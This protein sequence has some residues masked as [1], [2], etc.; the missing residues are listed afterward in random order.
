MNSS[1]NTLNTSPN[2]MGRLVKMI[3]LG[4]SKNILKKNEPSQ[5]L[6]PC[7][8]RNTKQYHKNNQH[9]EYTHLIKTAHFLRSCIEDVFEQTLFNILMIVMASVCDFLIISG[10]SRTDNFSR[11]HFWTHPYGRFFSE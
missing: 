9:T 10:E 5:L 6:V 7:G 4:E 11:G 1:K 8:K 3:V 2:N